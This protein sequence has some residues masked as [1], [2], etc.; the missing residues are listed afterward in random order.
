M[1]SGGVLSVTVGLSLAGPPPTLRMSQL[2][3]RRKMT[4]SRSATTV[5]P[6]HRPVELT[7]PVLVGDH[8]DMVRN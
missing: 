2:L 4:G 7:G 1:G 3:A 8:Y 5:A 6:E